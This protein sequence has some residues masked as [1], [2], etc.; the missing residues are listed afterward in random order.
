MR[1]AAESTLS[2]W[3][4]RQASCLSASKKDWRN[5]RHEFSALLLVDLTLWERQAEG[6]QVGVQVDCVT[7]GQGMDAEDSVPVVGL[8]SMAKPQMEG[9][10]NRVKVVASSH[11]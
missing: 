7:I 9:N 3:M 8:D 4:N 11:A 1:K 6:G 10:H 5:G 2:M